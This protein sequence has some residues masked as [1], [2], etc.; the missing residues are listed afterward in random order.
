M[1]NNFQT[2]LFK[3]CLGEKITSVEIPKMFKYFQYVSTSVS[4]GTTHCMR[5]RACCVCVCVCEGGDR[6]E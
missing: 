2:F 5:A 4:M 6:E 1:K 3:L